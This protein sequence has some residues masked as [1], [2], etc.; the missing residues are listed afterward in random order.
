MRRIA[1]AGLAAASVAATGCQYGEN[2]SVRQ[3]TDL[4]A[5]LQSRNE[6]VA[7]VEDGAY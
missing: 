7:P 6:Y 1:L 3:M 5:F 4:V 2:M